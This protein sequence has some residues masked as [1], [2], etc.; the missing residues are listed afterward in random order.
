M[1]FIILLI[2]L[3][4]IFFPRAAWFLE[5]GWKIKDAEPSETALIL[6]RVVGI[7]ICIIAIFYMIG[8]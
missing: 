6:N 8:S 1:G 4:N 3:F 7:I 2:G 5:I